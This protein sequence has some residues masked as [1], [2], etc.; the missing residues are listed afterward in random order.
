MYWDMTLS[1]Y[2]EGRQ[3]KCWVDGAIDCTACIGRWHWV[4]VYRQLDRA[5]FWNGYS[6]WKTMSGAI[7]R[8]VTKRNRSDGWA[9]T[10]CSPSTPLI[11]NILFLLNIHYWTLLLNIHYEAN[12]LI[13]AFQFC[14]KNIHSWK[15]HEINFPRLY[16]YFVVFQLVV[17]IKLLL[18]VLI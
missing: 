11:L 12:M 5:R 4:E 2:I 13:L 18:P 15:I 6:S 17:H 3:V 16:K 10:G 1:S 8:N 9:R 14:N 7:A